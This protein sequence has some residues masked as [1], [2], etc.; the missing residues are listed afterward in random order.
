MRKTG[1]YFV[2][3]YKHDGRTGKKTDKLVWDICHYERTSKTSGLWFFHGQDQSIPE[4]F[5]NKIGKIIDI[6]SAL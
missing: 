2:Q 5:F 3:Y 1:Y 6:T 4:I